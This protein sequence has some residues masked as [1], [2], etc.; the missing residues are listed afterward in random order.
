M[1]FTNTW[2]IVHV[3]QEGFA[4]PWSMFWW[5]RW[6]EHHIILQLLFWIWSVCIE[7]ANVSNNTLLIK[8]KAWLQSILANDICFGKS[9]A[10]FFLSLFSRRA[11][12]TK[13]HIKRTSMFYSEL[14]YYGNGLRSKCFLFLFKACG[15]SHLTNVNL[16][17][18]LSLCF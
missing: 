3:D 11:S 13:V 1:E 8:C 15:V 4:A 14:Q 6:L 9:S 18:K 17:Y 16:N 10:S 2:S 12:I 7:V 5:T